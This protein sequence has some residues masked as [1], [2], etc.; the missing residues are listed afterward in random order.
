MPNKTIVA[1]V[2]YRPIREAVNW[3]INAVSITAVIVYLAMI[4][5]HAARMDGYLD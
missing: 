5:I 2:D 4:M 1:I 3:I